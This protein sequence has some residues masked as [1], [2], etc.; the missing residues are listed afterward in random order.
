MKKTILFKTGVI[1]GTTILAV[2]MVFGAFFYLQE[3]GNR[4]GQLNRKS[5]K[6]ARRMGNSFVLPAW[7]H[8]YGNT[9]FGGASLEI[10]SGI[11]DNE[12]TDRD[13]LAIVAYGDMGRLFMGKIRNAEGKVKIY[14]PKRHARHLDKA[15]SRKSVSLINNERTVGRLDIYMPDRYL[16]GDLRQW[17]FSG[18]L[19]LLGLALFTFFV[20]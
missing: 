15:Y 12:M 17:A 7:D 1:I 11:I 8:L 10:A 6:I 16:A 19:M 18:G 3:R 2:V 20:Q 13:I 14:F 4:T 5:E 9:V